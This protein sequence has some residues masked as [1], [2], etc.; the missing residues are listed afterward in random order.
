MATP[1]QKVASR[2]QK[3]APA[4]KGCGARLGSLDNLEGKETQ[5]LAPAELTMLSKAQEFFQ[6]CD[7]EGKGFIAK[8]DMQVTSSSVRINQ[9]RKM[10]TNR[11][12]SSRRRRCTSPEGKR[13]WA[14]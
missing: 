6:T 12:P 13:I 5:E 7:V 11:W 4:Q 10:Q 14:T 1:D 9:M 8:G 3:P 2:A